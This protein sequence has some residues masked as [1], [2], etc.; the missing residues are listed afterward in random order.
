MIQLPRHI[1]LH[2]VER[3]QSEI[4][5][6]SKDD[7]IEGPLET[8]ESGTYISNL[9]NTSKKWD[10]EKIQV[11]LDCQQVNKDMYQTYEPIP[12]SEELRHKLWVCDHLSC[13][14]SET[15]T[16][17]LKLKKKQGSCL[18]FAPPGEYVAI[19]EW[20]WEQAQPAARYRSVSEKR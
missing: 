18:H 6:M 2:H 14:T 15:A 20:L 9:V 3:L 17:N 16:I 7:I 10:P 13:S 1:P 11:T 12:T 8:E 5:K 4:N 19:K